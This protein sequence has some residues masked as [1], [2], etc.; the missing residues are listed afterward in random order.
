MAMQ[1]WAGDPPQQAITH[2]LRSVGLVFEARRRLL[3]PRRKAWCGPRGIEPSAERCDEAT[4]SSREDKRIS[5]FQ[6]FREVETSVPEEPETDPIGGENAYRYVAE[7]LSD[8][9][10]CLPTTAVSAASMTSFAE[11]W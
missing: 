2:Q 5:D 10:S 8:A 9:A 7:A 6:K 11:A 3:G 1:I 4:K